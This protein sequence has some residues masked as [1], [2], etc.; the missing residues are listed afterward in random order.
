MV[1]QV[2]GFVFGGAFFGFFAKRSQ[3]DADYPPIRV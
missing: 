1:A 3:P 2:G